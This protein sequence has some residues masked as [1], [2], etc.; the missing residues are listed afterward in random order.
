M[1][2]F[3]FYVTDERYRVRSLMLVQTKDEAAARVL[4]ERML[5]A[6]HHNAVEVWANERWLFSVGDPTPVEAAKSA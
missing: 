3:Q 5:S 2:D 6:R 4:A 1:A